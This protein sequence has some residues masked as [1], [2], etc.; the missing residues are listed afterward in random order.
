[1]EHL[2]CE[3][4]TSNSIQAEPGDAAIIDAL[5]EA[6]LRYRTVADFTY[7]WEYWQAPDG[8]LRYIS[9]SCE[10]I[11]GYP[12]E[13]LVDDPRLLG[14]LVL[15]QDRQSWAEHYHA[16]GEHGPREIQFRILR[17]DGEVRWIEH[18]C[19]PVADDQGA[20]LGYRVS[21]RDITERKR[22][23]EEL[24]QH[25][26]HLE[27]LVEARTGQLARINA[28]LRAELA[29]RE[30][31]ERALRASQHFLESTLD[32]LS[33]RIA[34]L[35]ETVTIVAVNDSW[36]RYAKESGTASQHYGVG[37]SY[38]VVL[39]S[40]MG[41]EHCA[42]EAAAGIRELISGQ[43]D[44]F[45]IEYAERTPGK[46]SW[47]VMRATRFESDKG[48]RVVAAHEDI[49][50][51]RQVEETRS[52]VA[53]I[54]E[55]SDDAIIGKSLEG[56]IQSWNSGAERLYGYSAEEAVGQSI[57]ILL[58]PDRPDE[59]AGILER[60]A[61]GEFVDQLETERVRKDGTRV[62]VSL[63]I[64]PIRGATG[65]I[66]GAA[67]I[68]RDMSVRKRAEQVLREAKEA[69]EE[70]QQ[71]ADVARQ[72]EANRRREAE[73]RRQ[74][75]EGLGDILT[76]LNSNR[77]L[78]EVLDYIAGQAGRLLDTRA[79]G[80]YSLESEG[81]ELVVQAIH[82]PLI[83]YVAG[84]E[85]PIGQGVLKRAMDL[86][87]AVAVPDIVAALAEDDNLALD[88]VRGVSDRSWTSV[89]GAL[90]AVP[91]VFLDRV[92][93]G[94]LLYY[95]EVHDFSKEEIE[96]A[97][98]FG[99]QVA[100]AIENARLREQSELAA[101]MA[102]RDRLARE[103]HDAVTQT[104]FSASLIAEA[105]PHVWRRDPEAG[106]RGLKE[107]RQ[108]TQ[109]AA[110]E[111]RTMLVELRPA[112]LTEKPLGEL[113]RHLTEA[114]TSRTRVPIALAVEGSGMLPPDVQ[115]VLYRIAQEALNNVAKH[116]GAK[117]ASVGLY[118]QADQARLCIQD[119]GSGFEPESVLPDQ[120]GLSIM[121]ERAEG[122]GAALRIQS[123]PGGGT[124]V[125]VDWQ[126]RGR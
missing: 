58:P 61:L 14:E 109:G 90:L 2:D 55:S 117:R 124:K 13:R 68:A 107:L 87:K 17:S 94:I 46:E 126:D 69:A 22:A 123:Q 73:R 81:D 114:M 125:V 6:E 113:L 40:A 48:V 49:S 29:D 67:T 44:E 65:E 115:I 15:T 23:E 12:A 110:A 92:Y 20:F 9:P 5:R 96:L 89:Y 77:S 63:K 51:R 8:T 91:I 64:S 98:A 39:D 4:D 121:H 37:G 10:R 26:R 93:G 43:R 102:E 31:A 1:M 11:T 41:D 120:F 47:H 103:L 71:V 50:E 19:Q 79:V 56:I 100:L 95:G 72:G 70:A 88:P 122:I 27:G 28:A 24:Q 76:V 60:L 99:D 105:M 101:A 7:D 36:R 59:V 42:A 34:I 32:S 104:L 85:I 116:A 16:S 83:T 97:V 3:H 74:I 78:D 21:N 82:G 35:D 62:P 18:I 54:V 33:A 52:R 57:A 111:M 25:R 80:I 45:M 53:A 118:N 30:Q 66:V 84:A 112:A 86:R 108:L 106:Q 38:L 119:D 75:A